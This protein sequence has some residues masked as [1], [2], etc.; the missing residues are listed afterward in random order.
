MLNVTKLDKCSVTGNAF[1]HLDFQLHQKIAIV[2]MNLKSARHVTDLNAVARANGKNG[3]LVM[4]P[5]IPDTESDRS[6]IHV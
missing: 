2:L 5:A 4:V 1:V 3:V 6:Q